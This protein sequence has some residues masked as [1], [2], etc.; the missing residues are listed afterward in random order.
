[1]NF[2]HTMFHFLITT[3]LYRYLGVQESVFFFQFATLLGFFRHKIFHAEP[4]FGNI[5]K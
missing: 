3:Y 5:V 1:M 4:Y 2:K